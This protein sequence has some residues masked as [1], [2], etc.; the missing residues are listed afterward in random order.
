M[1]NKNIIEEEVMTKAEAKASGVSA[2]DYKYVID[3]IREA[4]EQYKSIESVTKN[5]IVN[6]YGLNVAIIEN[7]LPYKKEDIPEMDIEEIKSFLSKYAIDARYEYADDERLR[8]VMNTV[9]DA[10][11]VLLSSKM[12]LSELKEDSNDILNEYFNYMNSNK[13]REI[14]KNRLELMKKSLESVTDDIERKKIQK[15]ITNLEATISYSF[16]YDRFNKFGDDEIESIKFAFFDKKRGQYVIDKYISK[17]HRFGF[18]PNI[19]HYLFNIEENFLPEKYHPFNNL[20]LFFYMRMAA[21]A[22]PEDKASKMNIQALTGA[23]S[24]LMYHR[25]ETTEAE[26]EFILLIQS[27]VDK[28]EKYRDYF[29]ENN[30]MAPA[31]PERIAAEEAHKANRKAAVIKKLKELK[32]EGYDEDWDLDDLDKYLQ[33]AIETMTKEQAPKKDVDVTDD[34]GVTNIT[35]V[36]QEEV[37]EEVTEIISEEVISIDELGLDNV[38]IITVDNDQPKLSLD[39]ICSKFNITYIKNE[40]GAVTDPSMYYKHKES[41]IQL[42]YTL[43]NIEVIVN[44]DPDAFETWLKDFL[45]ELDI[46]YL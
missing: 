14:Q 39:E 33:D 7:I 27:V 25:F 30:S 26:K 41:V 13:V 2:S 1:D 31:H 34:E 36:I 42:P 17:I 43:E 4:E 16:L 29:I 22:N 37:A 44:N 6:E 9:K 15:M 20:F 19:W 32:V 12:E 23:M 28:F 11:L 38:E 5:M 8:I 18:K 3:L 35:P 10:S 45:A 40:D 21:H 24:N 46:E